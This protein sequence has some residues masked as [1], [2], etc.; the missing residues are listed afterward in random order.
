MG[1]QSNMSG[2][3]RGAVVNI[4][5]TLTNVQQHRDETRAGAGAPDRHYH[6]AAN[7]G[8]G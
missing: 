2:D 1:N 7:R 8:Y 6:R 3:F 4:R 5:S